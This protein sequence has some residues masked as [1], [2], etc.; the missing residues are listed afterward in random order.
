M[1]KVCIE[2]FS[3]RMIAPV[4]EQGKGG[5]EKWI[6]PVRNHHITQ[7]PPTPTFPFC[8]TFAHSY[9]IFR[10]FFFYYAALASGTQDVWPRPS[11]LEFGDRLML[12]MLQ[13][14]S[15]VWSLR[16]IPTTLFR[17]PFCCATLRNG[18]PVTLEQTF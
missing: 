7:P 2:C 16:V 9:C 8:A 17:K 14:A 3:F 13:I 6:R 15:S 5:I 11:M 12:S 4:W 18:L 1:N 10:V